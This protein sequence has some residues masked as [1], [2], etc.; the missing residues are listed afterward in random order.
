MPGTL[1][2]E[3][4]NCCLVLLSGYLRPGNQNAKVAQEAVLD[5]VD[6]AMNADSL[7][8]S[9]RITQDAGL[10]HIERLLDHIQLAQPVEARHLL[11]C[12]QLV[13]VFVRHHS[14]VIQPHV[15]QTE[16]TALEDRFDPAATKVAAHNDVT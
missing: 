3:I 5:R 7:L 16:T 14:Y 1:A 15:A 10:G 2:C 6:P 8:P 11:Q 4:L 9:P 13:A 12:S